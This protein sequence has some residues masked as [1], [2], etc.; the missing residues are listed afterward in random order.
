MVTFLNTCYRCHMPWP[1]V[2]RYSADSGAICTIL[3]PTLLFGVNGV[4]DC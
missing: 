3:Y 4:F 2:V 1:T